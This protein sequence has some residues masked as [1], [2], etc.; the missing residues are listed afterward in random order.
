M[1]QRQFIRTR[2]AQIL[3]RRTRKVY[4]PVYTKGILRPVITDG[5]GT[6]SYRTRPF[7]WTRAEVGEEAV[8][9]EEEAD[10]YSSWADMDEEEVDDDRVCAFAD[11]DVQIVEGEEEEEEEEEE[12]PLAGTS[13]WDQATRVAHHYNYNH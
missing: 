13:T 5:G 10:A 12:E 7:G 8:T 6:F 11:V 2:R 4:K 3:T 1:P 9:T